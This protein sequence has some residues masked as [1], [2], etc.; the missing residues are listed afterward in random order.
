MNR[1][2][3]PVFILCT[4]VLLTI[5]SFLPALASPKPNAATDS[6]AKV[7][8]H[9]LTTLP[10]GDKDDFSDAR[11]GFIA[12][13]PKVIR[14]TKGTAIW[15]TDTY[16]FLG[17]EKAPPTV[18]PSLWRMGQ[19]NLVQGLFKVTDRIYQVRGMDLANI[20][21]IEGN[22]GYIVIDPLTSVETAR[23]A[24][25]LLYQYRGKKPV[26]AVIYT[27]SHIDHFAGVGGV[28]SAAD[29]KAGKVSI[30]APK[31]FLEHAVSENVLAGN[32]MA[33]RAQYMYGSL[34]PRGPAGQVDAGLGKAVSSGTISLIAPTRIIDTTGTEMTVDGVQIVF[35]YTPGTEAP[36]EMNLYFPRFR[37]LCMAE[38]CTHTLHNLYTLRGAQV[39]DAKAWSHFLNESIQLFGD[40]S[41]VMFASHHWPRWGRER[42]VSMLSKQRDMY[43]YIH[44]Q[45]LRMANHGYTMNE[46][47][48]MITLPDG[49]AK[50]WYN[51]G[52]YGSVSHDVKAV[53]QRY[54]GWFDGN[55]A[56]LHPLPPVESS[57]RYV[58]FMGGPAE[59]TAKAR[60]SYEKGEYRW[61]AQVMNH[62]V[63]ADPG[64]TEARQLQADAL[65]QL[66]Y[67]AESGPWRNFYL[68]GA[69]ELRNGVQKMPAPGGSSDIL[70][71]MTTEMFFDYM[72]IQLNGPKAA[73][74]RIIL[75]WRFPDIKETYVMTLENSALTYVKDRQASDADATVIVDRQTWNTLALKETS[76]LKE[77]LSPRLTIEGKKRKFVELMGLLDEFKPWFNIVT[78]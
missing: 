28:T 23:A 46:I 5:G 32:A 57:R 10:F 70:N 74:K 54:L 68:T 19:L 49:L 58:E 71:A 43:K 77:L 61:V 7:N 3:T 17:N 51:R 15:D 11:R 67:Q 40:R 18:H 48:E 20:T 33:R 60:R 55:P 73:G 13:G 21:F 6:T 63:F 31:G 2:T 4:A 65:E 24:L 64:N 12:E 39:R 9:N 47:A 22:T 72:A 52:N 69:Q 1:I 66:G 27:H 8:A 59:V 62:V 76:F 56:N 78:P 25:E 34:L 75:N 29:V 44:D 41:D 45:T 42:I 26:V 36:T 16:S 30:I 14:N 38:N 35:Q 53:Y 50:E 37:A